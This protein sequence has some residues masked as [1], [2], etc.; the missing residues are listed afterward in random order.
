MLNT[1]CQWKNARSSGDNTK[2]NCNF[3]AVATAAQCNTSYQIHFCGFIRLD[4]LQVF[5]LCLFSSLFHSIC[6]IAIVVSHVEF[7]CICFIITFRFDCRILQLPTKR[8][9]VARG[10]EVFSILSVGWWSAYN[11][12]CCHLLIHMLKS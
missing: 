4:L 7:V 9:C 5:F 3:V 6:T 2:S 11:T 8:M 12:C 1:K 10:N